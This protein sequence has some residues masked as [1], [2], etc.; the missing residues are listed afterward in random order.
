MTDERGSDKHGPMLD[1]QLD[2]ETQSIVDGSPIEA[3]AQERRQMEAPGDD[4]PEP[5]ARI[6]GDRGFTPEGSLTPEEVEMRSDLARWIEPSVFPADR[7][8][9]LMSAERQ[10][11]PDDVVGMISMLPEGTEFTNVEAVWE[12]LGGRREQRA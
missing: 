4:E 7:E 11:A 1:E 8:T 2:G 12:Q 3:R 6:R 9:L 5:D 10:G